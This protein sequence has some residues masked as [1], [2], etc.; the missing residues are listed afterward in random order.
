MSSKYLH[1]NRDQMFNQ[2]KN[3][4]TFTLFLLKFSLPIFLVPFIKRDIQG[5]IVCI[6]K[7]MLTIL[8]LDFPTYLS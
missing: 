6:E 8:C 5:G 7:D 1:I 4:F 2:K 3:V